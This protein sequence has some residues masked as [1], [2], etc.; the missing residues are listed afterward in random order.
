LC[1]DSASPFPGSN[2]SYIRLLHKKGDFNLPENFRP[3]SL[4]NTDLLK[5][6]Q[7]SII[8]S[9]GISHQF[10]ILS[11]VR[12]GVPLSPLLYNFAINP[13][14]SHL[15]SNLNGI[16]LNT[17]VSI[18]KVVAF[19][20][21]TCIGLGSKEDADDDLSML[22]TQRKF[23][24][25]CNT[26]NNIQLKYV[27]CISVV[28]ILDSQHIPAASEDTKMLKKG[29]KPDIIINPHLRYQHIICCRNKSQ[30]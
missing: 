23:C 12:Q 26:V 16:Q 17:N 20:D 30:R 19:A 5:N 25:K 15:S 29:Q 3:I 14:I 22:V 4:I 10:P 27:H 1:L 6:V 9:N 2:L 7:A 13:I 24:R 21:D 11:G 8:L 28:H 18:F